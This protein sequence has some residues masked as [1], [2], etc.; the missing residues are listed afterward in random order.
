MSQLEQSTPMALSDK[1]DSNQQPSG[2][3]KLNRGFIKFN[4]N[5]INNN[6]NSTLGVHP[7]SKFF[8][9][10]REFTPLNESL[11]SIMNKLLERNVITL[12]PIKQIDLVKMNSPYFDNKSF[13]QFHRQ[14]GHDTKKCFVLKGKIQDLIDNNA[15]SVTGV[16]DK[17]N[18][19]IAPPNQNLKIFTDP[20][21]SH[22]SHVIKT[23]DSSFSPD[24]LVSMTP[25]VINFVEQQKIPKEPSIIFDS[26]ETIRAPDGPLYIVAKVKNTPC[27]GVLIDPSCMV[28]VITE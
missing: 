24:G 12:P 21:P 5:I 28:N 13:C 1:G 6:V 23:N 9:K 7:I 15:I 11:H 25:N 17:G 27:H 19:S 18:K 3:F 10:E 16:N 4:E 20:L 22:T 26:S 14:P 8:K 2:K